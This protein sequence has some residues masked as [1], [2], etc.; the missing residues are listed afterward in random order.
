M[1]FQP[2]VPESKRFR[3]NRQNHPVESSL[4]GK[5]N[6]GFPSGKGIY[7]LMKVQSKDAGLPFAHME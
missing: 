7:M 5:Q 4:A 6:I 1:L 2:L 3:A